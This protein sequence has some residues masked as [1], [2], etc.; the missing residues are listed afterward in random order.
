MSR[1]PVKRSLAIWLLIVAALSSLAEPAAADAVVFLYHRFGEDRYPSTSIRLEQFEAHLEY[2]E[3]RGF[4]IWP[5][6]RIVDYRRQGRPIPDRTAAITVD[7]AYLSVYT[8]AYPRLKA[9]GWPFTVFVATEPVERQL[10]G[11]MSWAQMR[12]MTRNGA[13]FANHGVSHDHLVR[14]KP[15]EGD[16][17]WR[18]R[19]QRELDE[20]QQRLVDELGIT[21]TLFA[22]PYGEFDEALAELVAGAGYTAFGQQSGAIGRYADL[23]ALPRFPMSEAYAPVAQFADKANSLELPVERI[24]PWDPVVSEDNPPRLELRL[25]VA[26]P[27]AKEM[28]CYVTGQGQA[29]VERPPAQGLPF[30]VQARAALPRGRSRYNCTVPGPEGRF[31]WY[32]HSWLVM[33]K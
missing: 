8:Q 26:V 15:G 11:F 16:A 30:T 13:S 20:A 5:L 19:M 17:V 29:K 6:Q 9:R 22:Y 2:L 10:G 3:R 32:S 27:R 24:Q 21:G 12:E 18:A 31:Y 7:D 28:T 14:R 25:A 4:A 1:R 33:D 23:R